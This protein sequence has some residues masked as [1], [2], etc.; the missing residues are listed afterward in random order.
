MYLQR[1]SKL[2][3]AIVTTR[4]LTEQNGRTPIIREI[5]RTLGETEEVALFRLRSITE[6][7][8]VGAILGAAVAWIVSLIRLSPLPLQCVL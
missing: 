5:V 2:R 6:I 3:I 8:R 1:R 4:D 7:G